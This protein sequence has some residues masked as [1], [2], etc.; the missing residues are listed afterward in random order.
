ML[1]QLKNIS[2]VRRK[3]SE[4]ESSVYAIKQ[5]QKKIKFARMFHLQLQNN[6]KNG[7]SGL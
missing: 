4:K 3:W 2:Q 1:D 7:V 5:R 6:L